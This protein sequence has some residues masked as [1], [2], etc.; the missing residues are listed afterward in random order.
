MNISSFS[1]KSTKE[2]LTSQSGLI[3]FGEFCHKIGLLKVIKKE[4]PAPG[5]N[6]GY[7]PEGYVFP[8][9][10]MLHAGGSHLEDIRVINRDK[11]LCR[12]T[13]LDSI[14]EAGT[15]GDWLRR[16]GDNPGLDG[17]R[18]VNRYIVG[19]TLQSIKEKNLTLDIDAT[20][21]VSDKFDAFYT[22]KGFKGYMPILG[23]IAE[24]GVIVGE[25]FRAGNVAPAT[26]NLGFVKQC[27]SQLPPN[28]RFGHLRADAASYQAEVIN[29]CEEHTMSYAI[30]GKM[31]SSLKETILR[32]SDSSWKRYIDRHDVKTDSEITSIPWSMEHTPRPF[33]MIVKR[34]LIK[35]PD[36][37]SSTKYSY[38]L[39]S[40]NRL[41]EDPQTVLHWYYQRGEHSENRLKELKGGFF[42]ERMPCGTQAANAVFFRIGALAYN[43]FVLFK[44][45][46]LGKRWRRSQI[47]TIRLHIYNLPGKIVRAARKSVLKIPEALFSQL[48]KRRQNI[49]ALPGYT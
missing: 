24:N 5:S 3:L 20:G 42:Q 37:F 49:Q 13:G 32:V 2:I 23:H 38:H 45:K 8:L 27:V 29:Y 39:V 22:Y 10:M 21:I 15:V 14:P 30:G 26:D 17:L 1:I 6:R 25:E 40:T 12:L 9:V 47:Q 44:Q 43:L 35:N 46:V 36:L 19:R 48:K 11:G 16:Q 18:Q 34:T 7:S 4:L 33:S 31:C 41:E 28:K